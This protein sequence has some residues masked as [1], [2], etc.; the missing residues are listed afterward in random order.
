MITSFRMLYSFLWEVFFGKQSTKH[1][2]KKDRKKVVM[3]FVMVI[4]LAWAGLASWRLTVIS[5]SYLKLKTE[6]SNKGCYLTPTE[7]ADNIVDEAI[8]RATFKVEREENVV[9]GTSA[10]ATDAP[11]DQGSVTY[12]DTNVKEA[13]ENN[14]RRRKDG[15]MDALGE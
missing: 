12:Q 11:V 10:P 1:A 7:K 5:T 2:Y 3:F 4:A 8:G 15:L 13:V 9:V 6:M 14:V